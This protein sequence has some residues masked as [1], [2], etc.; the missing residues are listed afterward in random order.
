MNTYLHNTPKSNKLARRS[1]GA[2]NG[3]IDGNTFNRKVTREKHFVWKH[4]GYGMDED[5]L[6]ALLSVGV[7]HIRIIEKDTGN[8]YLTTVTEYLENGVRDQLGKFPPQIFYPCSSMSEVKPLEYQS[9]AITG[10]R[11]EC[12]GETFTYVPDYK[13]VSLF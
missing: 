6:E 8:E 2:V 9:H 4:K 7:I 1:N 13:Q 5:Q 11:Y 3:T 10:I 12:K